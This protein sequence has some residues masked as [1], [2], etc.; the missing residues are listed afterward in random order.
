MEDNLKIQITQ[1]DIV[2]GIPEKEDKCPIALA[3]LRQGYK[4]VEVYDD[5]ISCQNTNLDI[6]YFHTPFEAAEFISKFDEGK[7]VNPF[8]FEAEKFTAKPV[9][10]T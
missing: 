3:L 4:H 8:E 9:S 6:E 1:Q 5:Y 10:T 2:N 7:E